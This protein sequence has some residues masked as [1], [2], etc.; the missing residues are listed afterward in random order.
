MNFNFEKF[1]LWLL[2]NEKYTS[3]DMEFVLRVLSEYKGGE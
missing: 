3:E 1:R 2:N